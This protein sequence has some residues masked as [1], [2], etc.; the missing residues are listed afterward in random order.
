VRRPRISILCPARSRAGF[1]D[2]RGGVTRSRRALDVLGGVARFRDA[3]AVGSLKP[4]SSRP[5]PS[6]P[7]TVIA[8]KHPSQSHSTCCAS[9]PRTRCNRSP[10]PLTKPQQVASLASQ[11]SR[12][13][14]MPVNIRSVPSH[15]TPCYR[16][17]LPSA[18]TP[19]SPST[20]LQQ[21][22]LL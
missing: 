15:C 14:T 8:H 2:A 13:E 10:A 18:I 6:L 7:L 1:R 3:A 17:I 5:G 9:L 11:K 22:M 21:G 19:H 16:E 12:G 20:P 4:L